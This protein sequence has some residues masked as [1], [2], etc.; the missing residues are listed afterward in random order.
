VGD[1]GVEVEGVSLEI[2]FYEVGSF[3]KLEGKVLV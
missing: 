1:F 2:L 3:E